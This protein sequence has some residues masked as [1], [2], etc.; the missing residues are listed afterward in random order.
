MD[1]KAALDSR[2]APHPRPAIAVVASLSGASSPAQARGKAAPAPDCST[3]RRE[4]SPNIRARSLPRDRSMS[5]PCV[6]RS[7]NARRPRRL[8]PPRARSPSGNRSPKSG[9]SRRVPR[10]AHGSPAARTSRAEWTLLGGVAPS[11]PGACLD[12]PCTGSAHTSTTPRVRRPFAAARRLFRQR[13]VRSNP[14]MQRTSAPISASPRSGCAGITALNPTEAPPSTMTFF[15]AS[16]LRNRRKWASD[17]S[18]GV[19]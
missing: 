6:R 1:G 15:S 12:E 11:W 10:L 19:G 14:R 8:Q 16:S 7:G 13:R 2:A 4:R 9:R 3:G 18:R 17:R 5:A